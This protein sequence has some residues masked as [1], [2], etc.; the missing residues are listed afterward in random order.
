MASMSRG[1]NDCP[2]PYNV[3]A[4]GYAS[5]RLG[6]GLGSTCVPEGTRLW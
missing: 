2:S 6:R 5:V 3:A 1:N 4:D